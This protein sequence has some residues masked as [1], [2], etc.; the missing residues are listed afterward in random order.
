ME[1]FWALGYEGTTLTD[2]Q[3]AMGDIS[4]PS[5]Y[6][7][8]GSKER[9]FREA[10]A[11]YTQTQRA[12]MARALEQPTAQ[13][14][15][16]GV[17]RA[18]ATS[19]CLPGKPRGCLVVLGA[20]NCANTNKGVQDFCAANAPFGTK[21]SGNGS[22]RRSRRR[23]TTDCRPRSDRRLL[24]HH[25]RRPGHRGTRRRIAQIPADHRG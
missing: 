1:L 15:I 2:L 8:F 16:K 12:P 23:P 18:A 17:L 22:T 7:A 4:A 6:A 13:A 10:V 25:H 14:A 3:Q 9:L 21:S 19:F 24:H 20:I 11:F 5:F